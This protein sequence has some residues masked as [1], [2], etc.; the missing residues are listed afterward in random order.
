MPAAARDAGQDDANGRRHHRDFAARAPRVRAH[1]SDAHGDA[2]PATTATPT[3]TPTPPPSDAAVEQMLVARRAVYAKVIDDHKAT[4]GDLESALQA[5]KER[6][7]SKTYEVGALVNRAN[8]LANEIEQKRGMATAA[9]AYGG[10]LALFTFGV[11][12]AVGGAA[13]A[14]AAAAALSYQLGSTP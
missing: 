10:V 1:A 9:A 12:A 13:A 7:R 4:I 2:T 6:I 11:S 3:A 5:I 8:S 14:A